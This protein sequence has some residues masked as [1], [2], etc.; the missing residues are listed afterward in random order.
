MNG[1]VILQCA[2]WK[3]NF[4]YNGMISMNDYCQSFYYMSTKNTQSIMRM[5]SLWTRDEVGL[6]TFIDD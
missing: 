4:N 1:K 5:S 2:R 6:S 3:N